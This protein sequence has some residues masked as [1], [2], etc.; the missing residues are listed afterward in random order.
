ME[1]SEI[2]FKVEK[3]IAVLTL[4]RPEIRNAITGAAMIREIEEA[5]RR[6]NADMGIRVLIVTGTDPA[7]SSGGNI[8]DMAARK[9]MFA[10]SPS[11]IMTGYRQNVQRIPWLF[12]VSRFRPSRL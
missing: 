5:C 12:M 1:F 11:E 8:K 6:V 9:G 10:G 3:G 7:F 4:N 2:I